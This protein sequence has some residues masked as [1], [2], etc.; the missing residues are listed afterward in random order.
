[1]IRDY[2][3]ELLSAIL[4]SDRAGSGESGRRTQVHLSS[5]SSCRSHAPRDSPLWTFGTNIGAPEALDVPSFLQREKG[6]RDCEKIARY[7]YVSRYLFPR[8]LWRYLEY[9]LLIRFHNYHLL[10]LALCSPAERWQRRFIGRHSNRSSSTG[11]V[12][13]L[14]LL[15][16]SIG[17]PPA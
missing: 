2:Q 1:M 12:K 15:N 9:S 6:T 3:L 16:T 14:V 8:S 5:W 4:T 7:R 11:T 13:Q 10:S 17:T